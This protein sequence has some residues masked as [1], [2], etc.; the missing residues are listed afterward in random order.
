MIL[1][2]GSPTCSQRTSDAFL[3]PLVCPT[4]TKKIFVSNSFCGALPLT[5]ANLKVTRRRVLPL[6]RLRMHL[7]LWARLAGCCHVPAQRILVNQPH[8]T[9]FHCFEQALI[10]KVVDVGAR[11]ARKCTRLR[12]GQHAA[13]A[14]E[15]VTHQCL[16]MYMC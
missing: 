3:A 6:R 12:R 13:I 16:I 10:D 15:D 5:P 9:D 11:E 7:R 8:T 4:E 1:S 14:V 2:A